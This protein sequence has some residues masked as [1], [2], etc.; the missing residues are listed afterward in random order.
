[1]KKIVLIFIII[2]CVL[3]D[4]MQAQKQKRDKLLSNHVN[5]ISF[6]SGE[7]ICPGTV[8]QIQWDGVPASDTVK[9]EYSTNGGTD[10]IMITD[11]ANGLSFNWTVPNTV[12]DNCVVRVRAKVTAPPVYE[13]VT[14][15]SQTWMLK[16]LD[17]VTYRN[18]DS[19]PQVTNNIAWELVPSSGAWCYYSNNPANNSVYGKLYNWYAVNDP[20]D[21][22]PEGWHIPSNAEWTTLTT[23]LGGE[24]VAGGKMKEAGTSHW[25]SPNAGATNGSGFTALPGGLRVQNGIFNFL[26]SITHFWSSTEYD[27]SNAWKWTTTCNFA[28]FYA[29]NW[30]K[31]LGHSVRCIKGPA[32]VTIGTQTWTLKNLNVDHYRNG[33]TI[34]QITDP[35]EWASATFGAWCYYNN[36]PATK[37]T[38]GLLYNWYAVNDS[39]GLAPDGWHIPSDAEW[40]TLEDN[41]GGVSIAGGKLKETS[42]THWSSPNTGATNESGFTALPAGYRN[43]SGSFFAIGLSGTWWTSTVYISWVWRRSI[44]CTGA[45]SDRNYQ[46]ATFGYSVRCIKD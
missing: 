14:I 3:P 21:L 23:Y 20:R 39:R 44:A 38:Y 28:T 11:T 26:G 27:N 25:A 9:L 12:S 40:T 8:V 15:G 18:G 19:I 10:W 31:L 41:L 43:S 45:N 13:E 24:N 33:D 17:V 29:G 32:E 1:M 5:I 6:N 2:L 35:T 30:G 34:P 16:N 42:F 46:S 7:A 22:A 37:P 36:D 4:G